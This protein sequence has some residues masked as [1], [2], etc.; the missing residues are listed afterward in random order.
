[1]AGGFSVTISADDQATKTI[2]AI[3]ASLGKFGGNL[4]RMQAVNAPV[5]RMRASLAK[6]GEVSGI[7]RIAASIRGMGRP[8]SYTFGKMSELV[9]VLGSSAARQAWPVF[10]A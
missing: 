2:D 1:M 7:N 8:P 6:F 10:S 3:N 4:R 9:P 5:D